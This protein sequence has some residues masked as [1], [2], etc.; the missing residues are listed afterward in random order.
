[1]NLKATS[2]LFPVAAQCHLPV[3]I[4]DY[5]S[6]V[7]IPFVICSTGAE[8]R[9]SHTPQRPVLALGS[10]H[11]Y[12]RTARLTAVLTNSSTQLGSVL[13]IDNLGSLVDPTSL[14]DH[15]PCGSGNSKGLGVGGMVTHGLP[16]SSLTGHGQLHRTFVN[17][18]TPSQ[19][20]SQTL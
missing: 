10:Q 15:I 9:A 17:E 20:R 11:S 19:V 8:A 1:M 14:R 3:L 7:T 18:P 2:V 6:L 16:K 12:I 5:L 13:S 4:C